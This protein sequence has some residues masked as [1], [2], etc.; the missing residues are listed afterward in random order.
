MDAE[1]H[2]VH[3]RWLGKHFPQSETWDSENLPTLAL[4]VED[5]NLK[6]LG[7]FFSPNF[8]FYKGQREPKGLGGKGCCGVGGRP[9]SRSRFAVNLRSWCFLCSRL[10]E[11]ETCQLGCRIPEETAASRLRNKG[12][13]KWGGKRRAGSL[14]GHSKLVLQ[15]FLVRACEPPI[16]CSLWKLMWEKLKQLL[17][18]PVGPVLWLG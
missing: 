6:C 4:L 12:S 11:A 14:C 1:Y 13:W 10:Q 2:F 7:Y 8:V 3:R 18:C 16:P 5:E 9:H 17:K 15:F